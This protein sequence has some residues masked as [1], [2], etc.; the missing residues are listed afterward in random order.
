MPRRTRAKVKNTQSVIPVAGRNLGPTISEAMTK[1]ITL[2]PGAK[3]PIIN[4]DIANIQYDGENALANA[5]RIA[6]MVQGIIN[7]TL[8]YLNINDYCMISVK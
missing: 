7:F 5:S 4:L 1:N 6:M 8:P 2:M 3:K